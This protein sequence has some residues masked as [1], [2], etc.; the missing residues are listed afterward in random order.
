MILSKKL[1]LFEEFVQVKNE[2]P[3]TQQVTIDTATSLDVIKVDIT[4][5][6][7]SIL[8]RLH[9]LANNLEREKT[10][11]SVI[12]ES[13]VDK[14]LTAELYMIPLI[15]V[16]IV[17]GTAIG[18]GVLIKRAITK[19]KIKSIY[20][21]SVKK[22]RVQAAKMEL[23]I[24]KLRDFK[25]QE[26]KSK[27]KIEE[28]RKKIEELRSSADEMYDSILQKYESYK[29]F[30]ANLNANTRLEIAQMMLSSSNLTNAERKRYAGMYKKATETL[31][32]RLAKIEREK[33]E[34]EEKAKQA[35]EDERKKIKAEQ[36]RINK[37]IED[38]AGVEGDSG[39]EDLKN[40]KIKDKIK[41]YEDGI[42]VLKSSKD[43]SATDK[44]KVLQ[45]AINSERKKL[46][47]E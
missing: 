5:D 21:K 11:E 35:T 42:S 8:N 34:A 37:E 46:E 29:D 6:V 20:N 15:A 32:R 22:N 12:N 17:G 36:A 33:K 31:N 27:L 2:S 47:K 16:G 23:Y 10:N 30:L 40:K 43:K 9:D 18:A 26:D 39:I 38:G 28:F 45:A 7:D 24:K 4:R 25:D 44:I 14:I 3:S 13:V 1:M 19:R 41:E